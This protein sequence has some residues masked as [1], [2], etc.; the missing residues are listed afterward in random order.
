MEHDSILI[1]TAAALR[2]AAGNILVQQRPDGKS[3][4]GLWEFPGG[5][6]EPGETPSAALARELREELGIEVS[7][8]AL[9]P[10]AFSTGSIGSR[11]LL[12]LL[13]RCDQWQGDPEPLH[14]RA[15]HWCSVTQLSALPMPDADLPLVDALIRADAQTR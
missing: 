13:Y 6:V 3:M 2:D 9:F 5:K 11:A 15:L 12:L 14:A 7:P 8:E 10:F 4:A 1:V